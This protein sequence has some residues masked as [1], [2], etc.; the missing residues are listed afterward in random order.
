MNINFTTSDQN[1]ETFPRL[2]SAAKE[3]K[4]ISL[5]PNASCVVVRHSSR[6]VLTIPHNGLKDEVLGIIRKYE[7]VEVNTQE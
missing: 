1:I 6:S 5:F 3:I 7:L 2:V 4:Q